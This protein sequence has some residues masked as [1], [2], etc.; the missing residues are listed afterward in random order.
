M[1]HSFFVKRPVYYI[2]GVTSGN[3]LHSTKIANG[4][5]IQVP[6]KDKA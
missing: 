1:T 4:V 3:Q 2:C 5:M 6:V